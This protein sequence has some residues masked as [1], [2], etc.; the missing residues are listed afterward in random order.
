M[1]PNA[2]DRMVGSFSLATSLLIQL[3]SDCGCQFILADDCRNFLCRNRSSQQEALEFVTSERCEKLLLALGLHT[4]GGSLHSKR[5]SDA[6]DGL[7]NDQ[8]FRPTC[9][10]RYKRSIDFDPVEWEAAQIA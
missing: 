2:L 8:V 9:H 10:V 3:S 7:Y 5:A 6:D 4:L 1:K